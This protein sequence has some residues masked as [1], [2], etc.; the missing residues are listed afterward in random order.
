MR[1]DGVEQQ[2]DAT[3]HLMKKQLEALDVG[4]LQKALSKH[5]HDKLVYSDILPT[6]I[7]MEYTATTNCIHHGLIAYG[8]AAKF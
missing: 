3:K 4:L 6:T 7:C 8:Q 1:W 2:G 5:M